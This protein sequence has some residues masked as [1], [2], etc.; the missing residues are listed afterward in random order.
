MKKKNK[1]LLKTI[2]FFLI[3]SSLLLIVFLFLKRIE[4]PPFVPNP[5]IKTI[6]IAILVASIISSIVLKIFFKRL[7]FTTVLF[8][9]ICLTSLVGIFYFSRPSH[10]II[11]PENYTGEVNLILSNVEENIL[12]L[13]Q[14]GIGYINQ[15]TFSKT[16]KPIILES[17][18][19]NINKRAI[20][21]NQST[22]WS[23]LV[24]TTSNG[25]RIESLNFFVAPKDVDSSSYDDEFDLI[26]LVNYELVLEQSNTVTNN[27]N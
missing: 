17:S 23:K 13:D 26:K 1:G 4:I 21:F 7:N 19:Y 24:T 15:E 27:D 8:L 16:F 2:N 3:I 22:F 25:K 9:L 6:L 10:E 18:G 20:G 14:N 12:T 5:H 11:V